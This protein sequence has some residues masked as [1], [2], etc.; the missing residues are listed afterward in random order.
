VE[1]E[2]VNT[3]FF[4]QGTTKIELLESMDAEG[5]I[6]KFIASFI[7][8]VAVLTWL[9]ITSLVL[10]IL[11]FG[12]GDMINMK[13]GEFVL[14]LR[15]DIMWRY[16]LAFAYAALAMSSVASMA[17]FLSLFADNSIGPIVSTMGII[18]FFTIISNLGLPSFEL[19]KPWLLT[20]HMIA[21][22]GFFF[23]PVPVKAI[24]QSAGVML[25]YTVGFLAITIFILQRK[26]ITS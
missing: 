24:L 4:K 5:V 17:I 21:W 10:S 1:S 9:A 7:Y 3:A 6:A 16:W 22:K 13:S 15:D 19:I 11:I 26:D 18:V 20:S 23:D 14:L 25:A 12:T 8:T 2:R